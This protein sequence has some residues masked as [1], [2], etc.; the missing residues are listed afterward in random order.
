[1]VTLGAGALNGS[2]ERGAGV[3]ATPLVRIGDNVGEDGDTQ[4]GASD[5]HVTRVQTQ[6]ADNF[7]AGDD[8]ERVA[9][10]VC[11]VQGTKAKLFFRILAKDP[12]DEFKT[13][14]QEALVEFDYFDSPELGVLDVSVRGKLPVAWA[15]LRRR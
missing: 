4:E 9:R 8:E 12:G 2:V 10:V 15:G 13:G 14:G 1:M 3:S 5:A 6:M 7:A 11:R